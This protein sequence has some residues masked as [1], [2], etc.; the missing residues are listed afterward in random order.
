MAFFA[1]LHIRSTPGIYAVLKALRW[2][3]N[4]YP[5]V[6]S[7]AETAAAGMLRKPAA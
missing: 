7:R 5:K 3:S 1:T 6:R 4:S 2:G